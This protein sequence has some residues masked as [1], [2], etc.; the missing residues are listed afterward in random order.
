MNILIS[1]CLLGINCR[2]DGK[3]NIIPHLNII[4]SKF[5]LIPVCPEQ[6]GGLPTPRHPSEI[7][8]E[9]HSCIFEENRVVKNIKGLDITCYFIK[10]AQEALYIAKLYNCKKAILKSN[11]PSCGYKSIYDGTFSGRLVDGNG[12]LAEMLFNSGI[13]IYTEKNID[14]F[15]I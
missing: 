12:I 7:S 4:M 10:G 13:E 3:N 8:C 1:A 11:S 15:I 5:N 14:Y 9:K 2:Y 6:L